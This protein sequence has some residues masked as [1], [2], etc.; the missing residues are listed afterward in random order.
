ML[1]LLHPCIVCNWRGLS[2]DPV[3]GLILL[4]VAILQLDVSESFKPKI[5]NCFRPQGLCGLYKYD[6]GY[7]Y[8]GSVLYAW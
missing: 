3:L 6:R 2:D 5:K 7:E 4:L 1:S 8:M